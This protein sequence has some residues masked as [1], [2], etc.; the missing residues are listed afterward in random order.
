MCNELNNGNGRLSVYIDSVDGWWLNNP[1]ICEYNY[2]HEYKL[3]PYT[4]DHVMIINRLLCF[5]IHA[6]SQRD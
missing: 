2:T 1:N 5:E 4:S 6:A 3:H